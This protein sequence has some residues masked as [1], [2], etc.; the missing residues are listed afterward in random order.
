MKSSSCF[1]IKRRGAGRF[2]GFV[3]AY[4]GDFST[5]NSPISAEL[6]EIPG[7]AFP[8]LT[9]EMMARIAPFGRR[10]QFDGGEYLYEVGDR[11]VDFFI[12]LNGSVDVF[13]SDGHGGHAIVATHQDNQFTGELHHL[14][15][16]AVLVCAQ[17]TASTSVI[18]LSR[19]S[20][21]RLVNAEPDIGE[22]ILRALILRRA[23]LLEFA[24]GGTVIVGSCRSGNTVRIQTF[25][26]R[27][28][29]PYRCLDTDVDHDARA[30][31]ETFHAD[32]DSLP[33]V[34]LNGV[35]VLTQPTNHDLAEALGI[36]ERLSSSHA[37]DVVIVGAG[38][39]GLAAAVYA[40]SEGLNTLVIEAVGPGGQAGTSSRIENYLGF[41]MGISGQDLARRAQIQ[42]QKFGARFAVA[43]AAW[44]LDCTCYP[45][46]VHLEGGNMVF[47]RSVVVATG[48]RYRRLDI[49]ESQ[50]FEGKGIHY[51]ATSIE[52]HLCDGTEAVVVG[53]G[54]SAGQ[55]AIFLSAK[56]RHV[57]LLVRG[58]GLS[59]AMSDYLVGRIMQSPRITLHTRSEITSLAGEGYLSS[60]RWG[61]PGKEESE[62]TISNLFLMIGAVPNTDWLFG[63]VE[64]DD[65]GFIL[66]GYD[67]DGA[68]NGSPYATSVPGIFAVGDVRAKSIKR[69]ASS[70]GEGSV[71][72]HSIHGWL[73]SNPVSRKTAGRSV[74]FEDA[75]GNSL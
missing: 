57:H 51:A 72:V 14:S 63:C 32:A 37:Y 65:R 19:V 66:T 12:I 62:H 60:V 67:H 11:E 56:A 38:P 1:P 29:Y 36:T 55:A 15:G 4:S 33:I 70:V 10:D 59:D 46:G 50:R 28:G 30:A 22:I 64:R 40:A 13:E 39:S 42:A 75:S 49:P 74:A 8:R 6:R 61:Q 34:V 18:R 7:E 24:E 23:R 73:A 17:T 45:F 26:E 69:V 44:R 20:L 68:P 25:L 52:A 3:M 16:R 43:E 2:R 48:A 35:R 58:D 5:A 31:M 54:N 47:G 21:L 27:N 71:V 53:G 41:P 9:P